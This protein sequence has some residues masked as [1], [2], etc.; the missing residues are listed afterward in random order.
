MHV[1][2]PR[3]LLCLCAVLFSLCAVADDRPNILYC[4]ADDW[5]YPHAG[6][7]GDKVIHMPNFDKVARQGALFTHAFS[8]APSCTPSRAAML[9][10]RAV[11]Q[12]REG[13]HLWSFLPLEFETYPD[14]LERNGYVV[15][16]TMKGWAPGDF[17]AGGRTRNPAGP[18]FANFE[19]FLKTVPKDKP[20]CFWFGSH[21]PHRP[22][23]KGQGLAAGM[24][25]EDVKVPPFWPDTKETRS[26]ILDYYEAAQRFD[27]Q[28]GDCLVALQKHGFASNTLVVVTGD[29]GWPF[30]RSK[31]NLYDSGTHQ[32]LAIRW[33]GVVKPGMVIDGFVNLYDIAPTFLNVAGVKIPSSMTGQSWVPLLQG[34]G[35][36]ARDAVFVERERHANVR[37]GDLSYP[38]RAVRTDSFLYIRNL[39]PDRWP[40]GDPKMYVAVGPFGDCDNGPTKEEIVSDRKEPYFSLGFGKRPD[41]ELYDLKKDPWEMTNVVYLTEYAEAKKQMRAR[42]DEWMQKTDDPRYSHDDDRW[43]KYPYFGGKGPM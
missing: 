17:R 16:F 41:E 28:V 14:I 12:L 11:H 39:R 19:A 30:P 26:D 8:A 4:L 38:A 9:T 13:S 27:R 23:K 1:F 5:A 22:Y 6:V 33:P 42:L 2:L 35:Q 40:A 32:P 25:I 36:A 10:G 3:R 31:A 15:G 29:N 21:F 7:Y 34:K 24:K 20:F 37:K 43:D 18:N